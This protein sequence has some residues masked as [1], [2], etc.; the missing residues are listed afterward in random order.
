MPES[1]AGQA[2]LSA[3]ELFSTADLSATVEIQPCHACSPWFLEAEPHDGHVVVREWHDADCTHLR[4]LMAD[5]RADAEGRRL[6]VTGRL[7]LRYLPDSGQVE[8]GCTRSG[9]TELISATDTGAMLAAVKA[10]ASTRPCC[11]IS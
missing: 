3:F 1:R 7:T 8:V 10:F 6:A 5:D 9:E 4:T 11:V 2:R